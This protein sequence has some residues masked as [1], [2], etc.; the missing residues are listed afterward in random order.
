MCDLGPRCFT[1]K[2]LPNDHKKRIWGKIC[3]EEGKKKSRARYTNQW[4]YYPFSSS[5]SKSNEGWKGSRRDLMQWLLSASFQGFIII[6]LDTYFLFWLLFVLLLLFYFILLLLREI[7]EVTC[8]CIYLKFHIHMYR[9]T[10]FQTTLGVIWAPI[11]CISIQ[12]TTTIS[13]DKIEMGVWD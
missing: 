9:Y 10:V 8:L 3:K 5:T 4:M 6:T 12:N 13:P 11:L 1:K 7:L 2:S